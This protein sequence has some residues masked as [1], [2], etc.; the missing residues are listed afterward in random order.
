MKITNKEFAR[1]NEAF[2]E[3]CKKVKI[4][5]TRRQASKWRNKK[6]LSYRKGRKR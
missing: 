4:I 1:A 5:P 3:A 6:G 2:L